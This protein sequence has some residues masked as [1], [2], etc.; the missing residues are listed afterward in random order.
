MPHSLGQCIGLEVLHMSG[1]AFDGEIPM[2][3]DKIKV[4][5]WLRLS[6]NKL[7]GKI[8]DFFTKLF[9]LRYLDLSYNDFEGEVPVEGHYFTNA[10]ALLLEGNSK[11]CGGIEGLHLPPCTNEGRRRKREAATSTIKIVLFAFALT[12][13]IVFVVALFILTKSHS[14]VLRKNI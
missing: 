6:H 10:C 14:R 13:G 5:Q 1:N 9:F 2:S 3:F 12:G 8:P 11:L 4:I 7:D